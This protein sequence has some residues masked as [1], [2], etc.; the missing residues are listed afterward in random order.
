ML[1]HSRRKGGALR[2]SMTRPSTSFEYRGP[3]PPC[4]LHYHALSFPRSE[5]S[6][7]DVGHGTYA[8]AGRPRQEQPAAAVERKKVREGGR[9]RGGAGRDR[10]GYSGE[11]R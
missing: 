11:R 10:R 5:G 8:V 3:P 1:G 6:W 9:E 7:G 4:A 2:T